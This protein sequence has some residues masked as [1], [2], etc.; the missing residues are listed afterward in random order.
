MSAFLQRQTVQRQE[1]PVLQPAG[2]P[3]VGLKQGDG[4]VFGTFDRRT[5]VRM[6]QNSLNA[7]IVAGLAP[8]GLFGPRT[9]EALAAFQAIAG[10]N[11]V[12]PV[13]A[14]TADALLG[15]TPIDGGIAGVPAEEEGAFRQL[16]VEA[17]TKLVGSATVLGIANSS[18]GSAAT[19]FS[20]TLRS[21][22]LQI[23]ADFRLAAAS[24]TTA[25]GHINVA[26]TKMVAGGPSTP[27]LPVGVD[28]P[29]VGLA[30]GDGLA[31]GTEERRPRVVQLQQRLNE[32]MS[33]ELATDGMFGPKTTEVLHEF[34]RSI[35]V[36]ETDVVDQ[37]T[38]D[39]LETGQIGEAVAVPGGAELQRAGELMSESG[40]SVFRAGVG[41]T[42]A[43]N[44]TDITASR[45]VDLAA[46]GELTAAGQILQDAGR[47]LALAGQEF[48][49][50]STQETT[51]VGGSNLTAS[52]NLLG[53]A[54]V[55]FRG[56]GVALVTSAHPGDQRN[57]ADLFAVASGL[58]G[59][60]GLV[61][62]AGDDILLAADR[63]TPAP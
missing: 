22:A 45:D 63:M 30:R 51:Q 60:S 36:P 27:S 5:R 55:S 31:L 58:D 61:S 40:T 15:R 46:G 9:S 20:A 49:S 34:Q 47:L 17:G 53:Q 11:V 42:S 33:A 18:L 10:L 25:T 8:D 43:V 21:T 35:R 6:L 16:V 4:L 48:S 29:M 62:G 41:L 26:G 12:E 14:D 38:A 39:A 19:G 3:L 50:G 24:L 28:N 52:G 57:I 7:R 37:V 56:A 32:R 2:N 59:A 44:L 1:Q 54:G 13:D 23:A